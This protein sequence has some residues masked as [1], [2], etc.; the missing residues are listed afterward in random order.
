M[1]T[2]QIIVLKFLELCEV[3][4]IGLVEGFILPAFRQFAV[5]SEHVVNLGDSLVVKDIE[6]IG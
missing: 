3:T 2:L 4:V 1:I 6:I 5:G